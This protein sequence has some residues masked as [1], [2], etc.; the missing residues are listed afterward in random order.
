MIT[1]K[2]GVQTT[3]QFSDA[4]YQDGL[5]LGLVDYQI[6]GGSAGFIYHLTER[7]DVQVMGTYMNFHTTNAPF[8]LRASY[9][10]IVL[11]V[12]HA[13]TERLKAAV[14]GGPR[15]VSSTT[16]F[17]GVKNRTN[18]T[19]WIYGAT[20]THQFENASLQLSLSSDIFPSGFGLLVQT[21]RV[22]LLASY[23]LTEK[24]T[25]SIDLSGYLVSGASPLSGGG[26]L[27]ENRLF[28]CT[29][30]IQWKFSE[31]WKVEA[32]YSYRLRDAE[33]LPENATSNAF[34]VMFT[35][36]PPKLAISN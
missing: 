33:S 12:T 16:G 31:W 17:G 15:F 14:Y 19:T 26:S 34:T 22:A 7:S 36:Y 29:P 8:G 6:F 2:F 20:L 30:A 11:N 25:T 24:I 28:S 9:P 32:S 23:Y 35:Y 18:D 3:F 5:R 13:L 10:G 1:E 21:D 4:S 27:P